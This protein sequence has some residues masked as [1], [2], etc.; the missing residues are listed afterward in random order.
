MGGTWKKESRKRVKREAESY[1]R[2]DGGD[3]Q[4]VRKL[5]SSV[6]QWKMGNW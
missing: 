5:S 3:V 2:G 1:M 6:Y 4:R